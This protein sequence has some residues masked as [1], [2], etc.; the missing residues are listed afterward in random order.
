MRPTHN[1]KSADHADQALHPAPTVDFGPRGPRPNPLRPQR[2]GHCPGH[3]EACTN[4]NCLTF[5]AC[6]LADT[7]DQ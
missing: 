6:V 1:A 5:K 3:W 4:P 7:A 2:N